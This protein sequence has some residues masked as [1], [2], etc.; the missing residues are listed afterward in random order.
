MQCTRKVY[1]EDNLPLTMVAALSVVS[2]HK[3]S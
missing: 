3:M 2:L 1:R